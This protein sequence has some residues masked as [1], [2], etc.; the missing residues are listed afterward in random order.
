MTVALRR[1]IN[2][3]VYYNIDGTMHDYDVPVGLHPTLLKHND[4]ND[5]DNSD[6]VSY[7]GT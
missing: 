5:N 3:F 7:D 6:H 1:R 2:K 4:N